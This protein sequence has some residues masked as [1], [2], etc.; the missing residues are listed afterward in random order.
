MW[1]S[2]ITLGVLKTMVIHLFL[3][4]LRGT[5]NANPVDFN[6][7]TGHDWNFQRLWVRFSGLSSPNGGQRNAFCQVGLEDG[8]SAIPISQPTLFSPPPPPQKKKGDFVPKWR[9]MPIG[10]MCGIFTCV[11]LM[12]MTDVGKYKN[13]SYMDPIGYGLK[14]DKGTGTYSD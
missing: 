13:I 6:A 7:K 4:C 10:S 11:W 3:W 8:G 9:S 14:I 1:F 12:F 5:C 2:N